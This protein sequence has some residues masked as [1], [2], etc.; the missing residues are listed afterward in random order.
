MR[1]CTELML[2]QRCVCLLGRNERFQYFFYVNK[3][4][5]IITQFDLH[6]VENNT[7]LPDLGRS[8]DH[9]LEVYRSLNRLLLC[10]SFLLVSLL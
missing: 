5:T 1:K 3:W 8:L 2:K 10:K 9:C 4:I 6:T 7:N